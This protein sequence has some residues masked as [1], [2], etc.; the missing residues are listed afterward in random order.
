MSIK[1]SYREL[2]ALA[3]RMETAAALIRSGEMGQVMAETARDLVDEGF[4]TSRA[5]DGTAWADLKLRDG[6]PLRDTARLQRSFTYI[7][8]GDG[9]EIGSEV[10]YAATHQFGA[11]IKPVHAKRLAWKTRDG[12]KFFAQKVVVPA[13][14]MLPSSPIPE[15]W[16]QALDD[17]VI[18]LI[19]ETMGM[20]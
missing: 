15:L 6:Q 4:A 2:S 12:R 20:R 11:T 8:N 7:P 10:E 13:R 1:G 19:D 16:K 9:F 5:P 18:D 3:S 14:P 17:A